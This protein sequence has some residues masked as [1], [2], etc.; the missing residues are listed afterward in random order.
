MKLEIDAKEIER[1][2]LAWAKDEWGS[3]TFNAVNIKCSYGYL[4]CAEFTKE[5]TPIAEPV[6]ESEA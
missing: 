5:E 3:T 1:V 6:K 4:Q 2:L